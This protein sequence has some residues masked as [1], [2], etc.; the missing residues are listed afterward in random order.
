VRELCDRARRRSL[1][2]RWDLEVVLAQHER[3]GR[4]GKGHANR[5]DEDGVVGCV[6]ETARVGTAKTSHRKVNL[7]LP[8]HVLRYT[9]SFLPGDRFELPG[10]LRVG[11]RHLV[12]F[13]LQLVH[14]SMLPMPVEEDLMEQMARDPA[15]C[16]TE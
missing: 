9:R 16:V 10:G 5:N 2:S 6:V 11:L 3:D 1:S 13:R 15:E 12:G 14:A 7:L 8:G 4:G